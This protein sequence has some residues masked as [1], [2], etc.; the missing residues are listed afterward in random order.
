MGENS[1]NPVTL[2]RDQ[3]RCFPRFK[4]EAAIS[5]KRCVL[6]K[7]LQPLLEYLCMYVLGHYEQ[8]SWGRFS[9]QNSVPK[10]AKPGL[11]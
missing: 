8:S 10:L 2:L 7:S 9:K 6:Q 11:S 4:S 3:W 1:P 5:I